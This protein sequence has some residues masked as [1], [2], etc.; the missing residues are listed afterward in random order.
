M[1]I[2][3]PNSW[4]H[5]Y[6]PYLLP[7]LMTCCGRTLARL[8]WSEP[9]RQLGNG[10]DQIASA[11]H[12]RRREPWAFPVHEITGRRGAPLAASC[13][14]IRR[15]ASE[16][17]STSS[18]VSEKISSITSRSHRASASRKAAKTSSAISNTATVHLGRTLMS[19]FCSSLLLTDKS[20]AIIT[21]KCGA[22]SFGLPS[23]LV[24]ASVTVFAPRICWSGSV[25]VNAAPR[26]A[27]LLVSG[28]LVGARLVGAGDGS[29]PV[30]VGELV[31][32][33]EASSPS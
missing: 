26:C 3:R 9:S 27:V 17:L 18:S 30:F 24:P 28:R 11:P 14:R 25:K 21:C 2:K 16:P 20:S 22:N 8:H 32:A 5:L 10:L 13:A 12:S 1:Y 23:S 33:G 31:G 29:S 7:Q 6:T 15:M 4:C 19:T